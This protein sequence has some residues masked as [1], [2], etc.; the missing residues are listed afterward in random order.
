MKGLKIYYEDEQG[1]NSALDDDIR[2]LAK[3]YGLK[4]YASGVDLTTGVRDMAFDGE[5]K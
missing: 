3:K 2:E 1:I 5:K 4:F